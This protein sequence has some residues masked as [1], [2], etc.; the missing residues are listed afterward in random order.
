MRV[1]DVRPGDIDELSVWF[2]R[3]L[4]CRNRGPSSALSV[5]SETPIT[6]RVLSG[7]GLLGSASA[8]VSAALATSASSSSNLRR[9]VGDVARLLAAR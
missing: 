5:P 9:T 1:C 6:E 8:S 2:R 3:R 7:A 4:I